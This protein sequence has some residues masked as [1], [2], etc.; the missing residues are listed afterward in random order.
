MTRKIKKTVGERVATLIIVQFWGKRQYKGRKL[1]ELVGRK[2][3]K[4]ARNGPDHFVPRGCTP[5]EGR[6]RGGGLQAGE[7]FFHVARRKL[8]G[9]APRNR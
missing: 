1:G 5:Q 2:V 6:L 9:A 4:V 8:G 7:K 3:M